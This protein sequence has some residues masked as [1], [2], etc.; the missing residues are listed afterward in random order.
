MTTAAATTTMMATAAQTMT[1]DLKPLY[2]MRHELKHRISFQD[3]LVLNGRLNKL[4]SHDKHAGSNGTYQITSLYFDTPYDTA[5]REKIEGVNRREK[6][7][8]RY[9]GTDTSFIRLEKKYKSNGLCGK[10]S[11]RLSFEEVQKILNND[12]G[13]LLESKNPLLIEFYSKLAGK[14]LCPKTIV[15][16]EREAYF[17][18]PGNVRITLDRNI[19]SGI[20]NIDFLNPDILRIPVTEQVTILEIKYDSFLPDIVRMAVQIPDRQASACSKYALCRRF[21]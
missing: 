8:L 5:L 1:T 12:I 14:R 13:F 3:D 15:S 9:Y 11:V 21:D 20:G 17:Y 16:Y 18:E 2:A 7:R 4:F 19:R 6:F 10:R